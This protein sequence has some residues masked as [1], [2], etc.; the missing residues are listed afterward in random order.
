ML[1]GGRGDIRIV[2][3]WGKMGLVKYE[4]FLAALEIRAL[5]TYD[6]GREGKPRWIKTRYYIMK[7][8]MK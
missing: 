5:G 7:P 6:T 4:K 8:L 2:R 1:V 3:E